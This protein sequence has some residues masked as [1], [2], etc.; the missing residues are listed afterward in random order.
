MAWVIEY[1]D[2]FEA[3]WDDLTPE[4]QQALDQRVALLAQRGPALKR[5]TVDAI[6]GSVFDPR[7]KEIICDEGAA[8]LRVLFVF[9]L[10]R[11][12]ILLIGGNK[13]GQW[14]AW[15]RTAIPA[16]D[17]LYR[18]HLEELEAEGST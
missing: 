13:T 8:S 7:M 2:E 10:R 4:E 11:A 17:D 5:P 9:D 1:T 18:A 15:Y 6:K 16:A 3:W 14:R 12:A